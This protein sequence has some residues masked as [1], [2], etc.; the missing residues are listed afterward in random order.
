[1]SVW[2]E[3]EVTVHCPSSE[4]VSLHLILVQAGKCSCHMASSEIP[5]DLSC[6]QG[7]E[8]NQAREISQVLRFI[9]V[10]INNPIP[11]GAGQHFSLV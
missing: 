10:T 2:K 7:R 1:M 4:L 11:F 8:G 3:D 5:A 6:R 9:A